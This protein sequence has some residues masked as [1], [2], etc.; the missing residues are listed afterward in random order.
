VNGFARQSCRSCWTRHGGAGRGGKPDPDPGPERLK[1]SDIPCRESAPLPDADSVRPCAGDPVVPGPILS[2]R[3]SLSPSPRSATCSASGQRAV[4]AMMDDGAW[5]AGIRVR[6]RLPSS[7]G[8]QAHCSE[9]WGAH[10]TRRQAGVRWRRLRH[11]FGPRSAMPASRK[12]A[13]W[14]W[15]DALPAKRRKDLRKAAGD[16]RQQEQARCARSRGGAEGR[17]CPGPPRRA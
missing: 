10:S 17:V 2:L 1:G 5:T 8:I 11:R 4:V 6:L 12:L 16:C 7:Q 15:Q 13:Q 14:Q 9:A 3:G